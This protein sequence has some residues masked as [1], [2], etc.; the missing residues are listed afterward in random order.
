MGSGWFNTC[1]IYDFMVYPNFYFEEIYIL[2]K[3]FKLQT[4]ASS[5]G[6]DCS[7]GFILFAR[8]R[9]FGNKFISSIHIIY[10]FKQKA[11][12]EPG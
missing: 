10:I 2:A 5:L 8:L 7:I 4:F 11:N 9:L 3:P 1:F 12:S 6:A